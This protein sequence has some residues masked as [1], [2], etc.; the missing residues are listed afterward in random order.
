[1]NATAL[2]FIAA[3]LSAG[4]TA[5]VRMGAARAA[6]VD[7]PEAAPDRKV[8]ARPVPLA[9]GFAIFIAFFVLVGLLSMHP[10]TVTGTGILP[11]YLWGLFI[12]SSL[13]MIG[14]FLDDRF[15]LSPGVQ[16]LFP[17]AAAL[18][19][20]AS[21]IGVE[22]IT[23]PFGGAIRLDTVRMTMLSVGG[24]PYQLTLWA[25]LF[26]F[27]WMLGMCYTTKFLDGL[28]GLVSGVTAIG[29]IIVFILSMRPPVLQGDTA[30][31]AIILAGTCVGFLVFNWHPAKI[32]LGEGGS[33]ITGFLLGSLA[34]ISGGKIATALLIMGIPILDVVWVI[35]RRTF[36]EHRSPFHTADRKHLHF[37]LL[38]VGFSH[39]GAVLFLYFLTAVFG[40][41]T[42]L[43]H[44]MQKLIALGVL[45]AVMVCLGAALVVAVR[46]KQRV[47]G[48][49]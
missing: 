47:A 10:G 23:N 13:L 34:I 8:H 49:T 24:V 42:L 37:R 9:G 28:D 20:V 7:R 6:L 35:V 26:T 12:G 15:R 18:V 3:A 31:L 19:V 33:L 41:T 21:G 43:F 14:G 16:I 36:I 44:G 5:L 22:F 46:R 48:G 30:N 4:V 1:M 40:V 38:D 39:R 45:A 17:V 29:S 32:F 11:K 25:D 27:V 2:F